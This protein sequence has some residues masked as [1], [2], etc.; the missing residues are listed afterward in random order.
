MTETITGPDVNLDDVFI[1]CNPVDTFGDEDIEDFDDNI[2]NRDMGR[3]VLDDL[4]FRLNAGDIFENIGFQ[5]LLGIGVFSLIY[6]IADYVFKRMPKH[7]LDKKKNNI[8]HMLHN[9][10]H[11]IQDY[12]LRD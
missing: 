5:S 4:Q 2:Q 11:I 12:N 9:A 1:E 3:T 7:L 6:F 8:K 10:N